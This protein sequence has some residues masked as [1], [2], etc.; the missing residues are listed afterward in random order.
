M[1]FQLVLNLLCFFRSYFIYY[2]MH[3]VTNASIDQSTLY[4]VKTVNT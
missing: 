4:N 1:H 3:Y 2:Q